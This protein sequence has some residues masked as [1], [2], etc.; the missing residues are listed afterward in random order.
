MVLFDSCRNQAWG[1]IVTAILGG[2]ARPT[3]DDRQPAN[4]D[5]QPTTDARR[6]TAD[7]R[8]PRQTT[9]DRR[10]MTDD[11][12]PATDD[13]APTTDNR[14]PTFDDRRPTTDDE[15]PTT[16]DQRSTTDDQRP[17]TDDRRP[18]THDLPTTRPAGHSH[19]QLYTSPPKMNGGGVFERVLKIILTAVQMRWPSLAKHSKIC[20][21]KHWWPVMTSYPRASP[22]IDRE[23]FSEGF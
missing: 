12:R 5:R 4:D 14:R 16:D 7:D 13:R 3:T 19:D 1:G 11:R 2:E 8:R 9:N 20:V 10:P 6:S 22:K 17:S 15:R 21:F 23:T 18:T